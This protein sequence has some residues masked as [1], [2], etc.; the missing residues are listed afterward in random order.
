DGAKT[1]GAQVALGS[2]SGSFVTAGLSA[3]DYDDIDE[4][5]TVVSIAGGYAV[6]VG[7]TPGAAQFCPLVGFDRQ[8]GPN[9]ATTLGTIE[10]SGRGFA[11]G[12]SIGGI[13]SS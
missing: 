12:G 5:G 13:A 10:V 6:E 1:Y 3:V 4:G 2:A 11:F 8:T 7:T 9:I